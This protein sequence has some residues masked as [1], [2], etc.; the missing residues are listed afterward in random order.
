MSQLK[1][2][3]IIQARM[4]SSRFPGKVMEEIERHPVL[5]HVVN[6]LKF[7]EAVNKNIVIA[8]TNFQKDKKIAEFAEKNHIEVFYG[9]EDDVLERYIQAADRYGIDIIARVTSDN[10]LLD[11]NSIADLV[12]LCYEGVDLAFVSGFPLGVS[13]E[14]VKK[15]AL[16]RSKDEIKKLDIALRKHYHEHV[17]PYIMERSDIFKIKYLSAPQQ[18]NRPAYRLTLDTPDDLALFREIY[19]RLYKNEEPIAI[20]DVIK[21][22]DDNVDL[23]K[24]NAHI[25]QKKKLLLGG[26]NLLSNEE[27]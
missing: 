8:T 17:T 3:A 13:V 5:W 19:S 16:I 14:V 23:L 7:S 21:L 24:I 4:G 12:E 11:F 10:P 1:A 6:R 20:K 22:L 15:A 9:S 2:G 18:L 25:K 26:K 27:N